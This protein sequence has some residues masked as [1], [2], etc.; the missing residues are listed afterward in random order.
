[1]IYLERGMQ[2]ISL[3]WKGILITGLREEYICMELLYTESFAADASLN[4]RTVY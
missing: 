2:F 3:V 4:S 1:M